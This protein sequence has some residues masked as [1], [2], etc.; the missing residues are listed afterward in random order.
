M[1]LEGADKEAMEKAQKEAADA[2][3]EVKRLSDELAKQKDIVVNAEKKFHERDEGVGEDRKAVAEAAKEVLRVTKERDKVIEDLEKATKKAAELESK[4]GPD[5]EKENNQKTVKQEIEE[6]E[7][8][9]KEDDFKA[10]DVA[11][12]KADPATKQ[13]INSS[14]KTY[15]SFLR[16]FRS[17]A[18]NASDLP[19]WRRNKPAQQPA[20]KGGGED[21]SQKIKSL[22]NTEKK[23]AEDYPDGPGGGAPRGG[24]SRLPE[25]HRQA[26]WVSGG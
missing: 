7:S 1:A 16:E 24:R 17:N 15:L 13:A 23:R 3:A 20:Q 6:I 26:D 5:G 18:D 25:P 10:L 22:F 8:A 12:E 11:I 4:L 14:D 19:R 9:L 2:K 21:L